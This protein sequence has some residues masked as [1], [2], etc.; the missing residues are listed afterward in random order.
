MNK[1][2]RTS[3]V[4]I[5]KKVMITSII[6]FCIVIKIVSHFSYALSEAIINTADAL[7][8]R[9]NTMIFKQAF[10]NKEK[11]GVDLND[12]IIVSKNSKDEIV[13]IDF[14]IKECERLMMS[15]VEEMNE[16]INEISNGGYLLNIPLGYMT[17]S[18]LLLNL[19]PK[20]PLKVSTT[21]VVLGSVET[22]VSEFGINNAMV[23]LYIKFQIEYNAIVPLKS[24][25]YR[26][27]YSALVASK[28]VHGS[29]PSFYN[30]GF[31]RESETINLPIS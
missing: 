29:V 2:F 3:H 23:E 28:I 24:G 21:D 18:P 17:N 9:E 30:G 27:E 15:I 14:N 19:G 13:M 25:T 12:L 31:M 6:T 11:Y 26:E 16:P 1:S 5:F 4:S 7:I 10:S 8:K 20:M 22:K